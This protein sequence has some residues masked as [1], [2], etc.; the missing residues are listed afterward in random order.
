MWFQIEMNNL[1]NGT[2]LLKEEECIVADG[3]LH[4]TTQELKRI[5]PL[6]GLTNNSCDENNNN[7][8][9]ICM[10]VV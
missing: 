8:N 5:S 3:H 7:Y 6:C 1:N 4:L 9:Y 2:P 10:V